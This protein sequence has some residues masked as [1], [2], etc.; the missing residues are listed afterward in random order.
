MVIFLPVS[1]FFKI[2]SKWLKVHTGRHAN[3]TKHLGIEG[4]KVD[5][6]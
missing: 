6:R 4:G 2:S 1:N 3:V 5:C